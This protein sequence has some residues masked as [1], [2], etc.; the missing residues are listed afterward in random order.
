M[1]KRG[2][3]PQMGVDWTTYA[4]NIGHRYWAGCFRCHDGEHVTDDGKVLSKDCDKTCH[5]AP[6]RGA[7]TAL[8]EVD[9]FAG[10][11]WHPWE[12]PAKHVE[13][14]AHER[15]MCH[16]CHDAGKRPSHECTD[17]HDMG[18]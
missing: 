16:E 14:E 10:A 4:N 9:P 3:F 5:T 11:D 15:V 8:G 17:C 1:W 7:M 6:Q 18:R 13:I 2:V 12:M